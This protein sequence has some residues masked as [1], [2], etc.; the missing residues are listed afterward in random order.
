MRRTGRILSFAH[1]RSVKAIEL[2]IEKG[3]GVFKHDVVLGTAAYGRAAGREIR[4]R[5]H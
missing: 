4:A 2:T 1:C 3:R 5:S